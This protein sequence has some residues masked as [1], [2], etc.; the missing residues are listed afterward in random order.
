MTS[1]QEL[2]NMIEENNKKFFEENKDLMK[3]NYAKNNIRYTGEY[4]FVA[5][6]INQSSYGNWTITFKCLFCFDN[7]K[8]DGTPYKKSKNKEH[9]HGLGIS[10]MKKGFVGDRCSHCD[11]LSY[12]R[13]YITQDTKKNYYKDKIIMYNTFSRQY[14]DNKINDIMKIIEESFDKLTKIMI[15]IFFIP[16][17]Q[18]LTSTLNKINNRDQFLKALR[19]KIHKAIDRC[20]YIRIYMDNIMIFSLEAD[21]VIEELYK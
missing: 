20:N 6:E 16:T 13:V 9:S 4:Y 18:E 2:K 5:S 8:K 19:D 3:D 7:Y 15:E 21:K 12:Y 17:K 10:E 11:K 14:V 1:Y